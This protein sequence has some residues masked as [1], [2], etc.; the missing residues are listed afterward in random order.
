MRKTWVSAVIVLASFCSCGCDGMTEITGIVTDS[1]GKPISG[2]SMKVVATPAYKNRLGPSRAHTTN[3]NG[4]YRF[5]FSH[6]PISGEFTLRVTHQD[7][8]EFEETIKTG[9]HPNH[10]VQMELSNEKEQ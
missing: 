9:E 8:R 4:A 5:S 10:N 2:A 6:A 3:E 1:D 7:Y